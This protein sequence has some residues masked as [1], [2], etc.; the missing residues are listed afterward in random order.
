[1]KAK[2]INMVWLLI[3]LFALN[4]I[5][6]QWAIPH[7]TTDLALQQMNEDGSREQLRAWEELSNWIT[8]GLSIAGLAGML[9]IWFKPDARPSPSGTGFRA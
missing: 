3:V 4:F 1:M 2:I 9:L 7:N 5:L 8:L 6:H